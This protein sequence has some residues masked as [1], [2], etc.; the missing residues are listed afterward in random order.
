MIMQTLND[1]GKSKNAKSEN[2]WSDLT[3]A[4]CPVR[5]PDPSIGGKRGSEGG[6]MWHMPA[7]AWLAGEEEADWEDEERVA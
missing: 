5:Q 7:I 1:Y 4:R 3:Q 2:L 6:M